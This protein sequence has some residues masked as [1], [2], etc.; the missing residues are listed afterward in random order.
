MLSLLSYLRFSSVKLENVVFEL[1]TT[2]LE[3]LLLFRVVFLQFVKLPVQ[4][5][6]IILNRYTETTNKI[7]E[8]IEKLSH[9]LLGVFKL[10]FLFLYSD[11]EHLTHLVFL[12]LKFLKMS[13]SLGFK[14]LLEADGLVLAVHVAESHL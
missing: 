10:S 6:K 7:G 1:L 12:L 3:L 4:L 13:G 8:L 5:C 11:D 14:S 9:I 2:L